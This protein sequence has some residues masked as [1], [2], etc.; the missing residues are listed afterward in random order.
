MNEELEI[1]PGKGEGIMREVYDWVES[2]VMALVFVVVV[3][4]FI[5]MSISVNG[6]SMEPTLHDSDRLV[7]I[8][9]LRPPKYMDIVVV[10]KPDARNNPLIKRVIAAGGQTIGFD[11][12]T[13]SVVVDG[14][15]LTEPYI[16]ERMNMHFTQNR[17]DYP[18]TVPDGF[19]FVMGD[20]RNHSW[21][22]RVAEL[23]PVDERYIMGRV[24]Y[25]L[26][27]YK[28]MGRTV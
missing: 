27:P 18:I 5:G 1:Q 14:R 3:F 7:C 23:G 12:Q 10:T 17:V 26:M 28:D 6:I 9:M 16:A 11:E 4:T 22:S 25:R 20:N 15:P 2:A 13:N 19:V 8:R 21:D 24:I